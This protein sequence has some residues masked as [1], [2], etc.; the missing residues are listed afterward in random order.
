MTLLTLPKNSI[1]SWITLLQ[2]KYTVVGP[3][4]QKQEYIFDTIHSASELELDYPT[5]ILPPKKMLLPTKEEL[6]RFNFE[7]HQRNIKPVFNNPPTVLFGVHTCDL[8]AIALL[9]HV[10]NQEYPDQHYLARRKATTIVSIECLR[11]CSEF[12]FCKSME[13]L[14]V[15]E[16]FDLH[17]TDLGDRYS[18]DI[19]SEKGAG[20]IK[21]FAS[22][23][24]GSG[25]DH[26]QLRKIM[27]EKWSNFPYRLDFDVLELPSLLSLSYNSPLW[28]EL[29][30]RCL[31]CGSC[32]IVCPSCYCFNV[33]DEMDLRLHSGSRFRVWDSCQLDRFATVAGG[34][35]FRPT[36]A[37]RLRHRFFHK[38]KYQAESSGMVGC[39]G[40]GR[41][42]QTCLV[43]I[44]PV[45]IFNEL[46]QQQTARCL[47]EQ[48]AAT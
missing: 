44:S 21:S 46:Y 25:E 28:E 13:T 18:L 17:L 26:Q 4:K 19:G 48:E 1:S 6:I 12:A 32:N 47:T 36:Q 34:H 2:S 3:K 22:V 23:R 27:S 8:H 38:G 43:H 20:L 40:C 16:N 9:D 41:C 31:A 11:P 15:H 30:K 10:L 7:N 33:I 24:E 42:A 14:S 5:T 45:D 35:N 39:V 37:S 29:E